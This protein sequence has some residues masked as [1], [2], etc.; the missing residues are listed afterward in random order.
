MREEK[1]I[2]TKNTLGKKTRRLTFP[3]KEK[4]KY[5]IEASWEKM[6]KIG[7]EPMTIWFSIKYS[8]QL[9][10][11]NIFFERIWTFSFKLW[12]WRTNQLCYK[13]LWNITGQNQA[14]TTPAIELE[15]KKQR[16][17]VSRKKNI[18]NELT[19]TQEVLSMGL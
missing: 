10:Y 2:A 17:V 13:E 1:S 4:K 9:S 7:L 15:N 8:N 3:A 5:R 16:V 14:E 6:L 12:V 19:S 11:F 18:I